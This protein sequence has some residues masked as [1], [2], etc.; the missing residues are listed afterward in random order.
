[1]VRT[2]AR[3]D[4]Q[5][6]DIP[7]MNDFNLN[8]YC[9]KNPDK[10]LVGIFC[11]NIDVAPKCYFSGKLSTARPRAVKESVLQ[12]TGCLHYGRHEIFT[13][14]GCGSTAI[15]LPFFYIKD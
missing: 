4:T 1:M 9:A 15:L 6:M 2:M 13:F 3:A 11:N 5:A 14:S 12:Q 8:R 10:K 7:R